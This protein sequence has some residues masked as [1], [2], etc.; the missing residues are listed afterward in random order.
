MSDISRA[1]RP[2]LA[3]AV[4]LVLASAAAGAQPLATGTSAPGSAASVVLRWTDWDWDPTIIAGLALTIAGYLWIAHRFRARPRQALAFWCGLAALIVALLSPLHVGSAYLFTIHMVQHMLLLLVAPA[5][6]AMAIPP[7]FLGWL[8]RQTA[9]APVV[10]F[11]WS[12]VTSLILFNGVLL[13]WHL[14]VM[15][16][17]TLRY[18]WVHALEHVSFVC[19]GV[20]F[21]GVIVSPAPKLVR[22]SYGVRLALVMAA[23]LVNFLL[24]FGLA[25]AGRPLYLG[26]VR[27]PRLWGVTPLDDLHLGGAVMWTM[28]QMMYAVPMLILL[29]VLL[30]REGAGGAG[31]GAFIDAA[32]HGPEAP[33]N[34]PGPSVSS[35]RP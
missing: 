26:Y 35:A 8:Y 24:G 32:D 9:V 13:I 28:G 30:R 25:F 31:A 10:R 27:A 6:L 34:P 16:D 14:P 1:L 7:A 15:Y 2:V 3:G 11:L 17:L 19:A 21:W 5:L 18:G 20:V 29:N 22:A 33:V 12:P 4:L 23:D